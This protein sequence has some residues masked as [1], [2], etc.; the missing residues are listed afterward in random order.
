MK[1]LCNIIL[2]LILS[3]TLLGCSTSQPIQDKALDTLETTIQNLT[4]MKA[5]H[6]GASLNASAGEDYTDLSLVGA[7]KNEPAQYSMKIGMKS[8]ASGEEFNYDDFITIAMDDQYA[9]T[10]FMGL[11][12]YK[13]P[14]STTD[15]S[16][17]LLPNESFKFDKEAFKQYLTKASYQENTIH[18]EFNTDKISAE[19]Q[20]ALQDESIMAS[21]PTGMV[22]GLMDT[23]AN[24][25]INEI[26]ANIIIKEEMLADLELSVKASDTSQE[27]AVD[28]N[29]I[30]K[31]SFSEINGDVKVEMP[32][33]ADTYELMDDA[34][35]LLP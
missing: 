10:N 16:Q 29:V 24:L 2:T 15:T 5:A 13:S 25:K 12:K 3:F 18:L 30:L 28:N 32:S 26:T 14:V 27:V 1:K 17:P 8:A 22:S 9:Y 7:F 33:D 20:K 19:L 4:N 21:D 35:M 23:Y 34:S 6:Y 11:M 31:L